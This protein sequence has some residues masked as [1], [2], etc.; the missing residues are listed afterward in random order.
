MKNRLRKYLSIVF[1][2][3]TI[4]TAFH[5]HN[6]LKTHSDCQICIIQSNITDADTPL[7]VEYLSDITILHEKIITQFVNF[8]LT[9][10]QNDL[11]QRAPP[12]IS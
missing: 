2:F 11:H 4:L 6:D 5:H 8:Y 9:N 7:D 12:K 1:I 3:A 10:R